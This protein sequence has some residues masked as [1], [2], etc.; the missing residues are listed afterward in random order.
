M[1][2]ASTR[3]RSG[4]S[5]NGSS[6]LFLGGFAVGLLVGIQLTDMYGMGAPYASSQSNF[7]EILETASVL[8]GYAG[9]S[10]QT[11]TP[12]TGNVAD[13]AGTDAQNAINDVQNLLGGVL[14]GVQGAI[15]GGNILIT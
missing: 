9:K 11:L 14:D 2:K 7:L 3:G 12:R 1:P 4:K 8:C 15:S 13:G 5:R 10:G 6:S